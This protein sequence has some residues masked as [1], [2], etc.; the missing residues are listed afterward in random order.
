M[1]TAVL[2]GAGLFCVDD[3]GCV[4]LYKE[5]FAYNCN[6]LYTKFVWSVFEK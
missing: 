1:K 4:L 2:Q 3:M 6:K 5:S